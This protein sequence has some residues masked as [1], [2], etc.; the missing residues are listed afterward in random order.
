MTNFVLPARLP[1]ALYKK[2][3]ETALAAHRALG[4]Y[5]LSRVDIIVS[6]ADHIPYVHEVN[7]IRG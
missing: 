1:K 3:Q 7:S 6:S 4:C 5:G 2:T